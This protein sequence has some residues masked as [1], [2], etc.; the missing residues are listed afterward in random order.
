MINHSSIPNNCILNKLWD[1][2][3]C[4]LFLILWW[5]EFLQT[6]IYFD[7]FNCLLKFNGCNSLF[8]VFFKFINFQCNL[9]TNPTD[10][11]AD[12][13]L[14]CFAPCKAFFHAL[15]FYNIVSC[16]GEEIVV[17]AS[18]R[19][20]RKG[21]IPPWR[22]MLAHR[23]QLSRHFSRMMRS[24]VRWKTSSG[25]IVWWEFFLWPSLEIELHG[26]E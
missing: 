20:T 17:S 3:L 1:A 25:E 22:R 18:R 16:Q 10:C 24:W 26:F 5:L 13:K 8:F 4:K 14:E 12:L 15:A 21:K 2:K 19:K 6:D 7:F 23:V 9:F 11:F